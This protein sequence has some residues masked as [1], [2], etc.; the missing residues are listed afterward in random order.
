MG[1]KAVFNTLVF[2]GILGTLPRISG[3]VAEQ[4]IKALTEHMSVP[5]IYQV[6]VADYRRGWFSSEVDFRVDA[7]GLDALSQG[8][9]S[10]INFYH[11]F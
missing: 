10:A 5:N 4:E 3:Q 7:P 11:A 6:S 9:L 8:M 1:F 2:A